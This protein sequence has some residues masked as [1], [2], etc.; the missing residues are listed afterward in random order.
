MRRAKSSA[1]P[2]TAISLSLGGS[3]A[4]DGSVNR[5]VVVSTGAITEA[6]DKVYGRQALVAELMAGG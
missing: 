6:L 3:F 2:S 5:C 4:Y 1:P